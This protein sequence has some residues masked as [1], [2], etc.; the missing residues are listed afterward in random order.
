[1]SEPQKGIAAIFAACT[2][3][4]LSSL[5][6]KALE[7]VPPLE[8]LGWRS[9]ASL[10]FFA[11][12]LAAQGRLAAI[13]GAWRSR[14]QARQIT[15]ASLMIAINW[16]LFIYSVH[17]G[18]AIESAFGYYIFPLVTVLIGWGFFGERPARSEWL[19]IGL[20]A[21]GVMILGAM[22]GAAPWISLTLA[23]TF[24]I[25]GAVKKLIPLGPLVS[26]TAEVTLIAPLA[27]IGIAAFGNGLA[28]DGP[29][30]ALLALSGPITGIPLLLLSY[31]ARRVRFATLGLVQ[32]W[33]PSLQ[34]LVAILL[35]GEPTS[36]AHALALPLIW[37]A[38]AVYSL[39]ALRRPKGAAQ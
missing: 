31:G 2:I 15:L 26:V 4:G 34:F 33:N 27:L 18:R 6:Y 14:A 19:A 22:L 5:F 39:S 24:A 38:L 36:L 25:Y 12:V 13:P 28:W 35:L 37:L 30:L 11:L 20:A 16:L 3:W 9:I 10:A 21:T 1:M 23:I 32:Y 29:T 8:V 7:H 17:S